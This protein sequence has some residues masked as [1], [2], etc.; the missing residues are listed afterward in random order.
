MS[1][2]SLLKR[3]KGAEKFWV[4]VYKCVK[5]I[6]GGALYTNSHWAI[7]TKASRCHVHKIQYGRTLEAVQAE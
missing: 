4:L 7:D 5:G 3:K 1:L 2:Y 6:A